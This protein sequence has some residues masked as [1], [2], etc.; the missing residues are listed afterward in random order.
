[1]PIPT[2]VE[3]RIVRRLGWW[4]QLAFSAIACLVFWIGFA[5]CDSAW[6]STVT[7][8]QQISAAAAPND[9]EVARTGIISQTRAVV[10][11]TGILMIFVLLVAHNVVVLVVLRR[12]QRAARCED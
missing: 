7:Q 5:V 3:E 4:S 6:Q 11:A 1:M 12:S 2:G 8:I 10:V 9:I